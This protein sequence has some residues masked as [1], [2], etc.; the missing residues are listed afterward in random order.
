MLAIGALMSVL[1][2]AILTG[3]SSALTSSGSAPPTAGDSFEPVLGMPATNVVMIGASLSAGEDWALGSLGTVPA[4]VDGESYS[5]QTALLEHSEAPA[6]PEASGWQI[7]PLPPKPGGGTLSAGDG[8]TTPDGGVALLSNGG[9]LTRDPGGQVQLVSEP[10]PGQLGKDE[11]LPP[12]SSSI[13][14][15]AIEDGDHTGILAI[16]GGDG[17]DISTRVLHYDE[18]RWT[19]EAIEGPST[20]EPGFTPEALACAGASSTEAAAGASG[21]CWLLASYSTEASTG[22]TGRL[23]LFHRVSAKASGEEWQEQTIADERPLLGELKLK[24]GESPSVTALA[25]GAQML[26]ATTQGVWIDFQAKAG[27]G[28]SVD[29]TKLIVPSSSTTAKS[30]GTW[31]FTTD[32]SY[33]S[34][35]LCSESHWHG[36]LL[37]GQYRSFAWPGAGGSQGSRIITGLPN[38]KMLELAGES[39]SEVLGAGGQSGL[40]PGGAA[41]GEPDQGWIADGVEVPSGGLYVDGEG[42]SQVIDVTSHPAG[43]E[44]GEEAVPFRRPLYALAQAPSTTPGDPGAEAIAVGEQGEVARY[45]PGQGWRTESLYDS[46]GQAQTPTLRG[47]AWPTPGRAY[48]VGDNG[49]MWLWQA[50][51][52]LWEPDPA[53]PLNFVKHLTAIAFSAS[54]PNLGYAVGRQGALLRFGKSWEQEPLPPELEE[55]NFTSVAF[56]GSEA[57]ATYRKLEGTNEVGGLA[58]REGSE[59][60]H[61][62]PGVKALF[63]QLPSTQTVLSRVA[64]LADGGAVAAGPGLVIERDSSSGTWRFS[65]QPLPEAQNISALAAYREPGGPVRAVVSID[66]DRY[67]NPQFWDGYLE[68]ERSPF[69]VDIPPTTVAGEPS[70]FLPPDILPN[71]GYV[72]KETATG[73]SDIEHEALPMTETPDD[74]VRP[75]PVLAL[76][77]AP[78]GASG[79]AVGGQT[80]DIE[81]LGPKLGVNIG[82]I[83]HQT[84]AAMRFPAAEASSDG[85]TQAPVKTKPGKPSF[86]VGGEARCE[87]SCAQFVNEGIGPEAWLEHAL[88]SANQIAAGSPG[89]M[90]AF[91]YT[92]ASRNDVFPSVTSRYGASLPVYG[93]ESGA[94]SLGVKH[95]P[96]GAAYS[97]ESE[98]SGGPVRVIVLTFTEGSGAEGS[99]QQWLKEE[100]ENARSLRQPAIVTGRDSIGFTVP[101]GPSPPT[102]SRVATSALSSILVNGGA[103]A[104]FFDAPESDVAGT[105]SSGGKSIP[106][107]GTGTLGYVAPANETSEAD[108]LGSSGFL[109]AEVD[110]AERNPE[111][112]V[113]PLTVA[114]VPN[115]SQLALDAD[116]GVLLRRSQVA[117]FEALARRPNGGASVGNTANG[118]EW[119]G[120]DPYDPIPFNCLGAN[121][122]DAVPIDYTFTSSNPDIGAFVAHESASSNPRQVLLGSNQLPVLDEPRNSKGELNAGDHF[123][124]NANGEPINEKGQVVSHD[125]SALFCAF[126]AG[127]TIVSITT[128][129]LTYSE[130]VT[131]QAGSVE[132]PCGTV[133]LID[134]PSR[135]LPAKVDIAAPEA[136]SPPSPEATPQI[137]TL[138]PPPPPVVAPHPKPPP[139]PTS[140]PFVPLVQ[141][142]GSQVPA[143]VPPPPPLVARPI[144][145]S[146]TAQVVDEKREEESAQELANTRSSAAAYDSA[147]RSGPGPWII[148]LVV[149]AAGAGAGVR[150]GRRRDARERPAF[151]LS[152]SRQRRR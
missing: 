96:I 79:L 46:A 120:P 24:P 150:R 98:G 42:Q 102:V 122:V 26:T 64:G 71:S 6:H 104:Y 147:E 126:N 69:R 60:W 140:L 74:P 144:P 106:T 82:D 127:T 124:E 45:I 19:P 54:N 128:G 149:I 14:Y 43:D 32:E 3:R 18:G 25:K 34:G 133:P 12:Q 111:T 17:K 117:L 44:L 136:P 85:A 33:P 16:P 135:E 91:L 27:S 93:P 73:W 68:T 7:L 57:L 89:G 78:S 38:R 145:P 62:D 101:Q 130:P 2:V 50:D 115:I 65:S 59:P 4:I 75:D 63:A 29:V 56:A 99:E 9:L 66:L 94:T 83:H 146:G 35:A 76:V 58:V 97:F 84:A 138:A 8:V 103:S 129:G 49:S 110:S 112:N 55:V 37:P 67:L 114:A 81:G 11:S 121:C 123:D 137:Q 5:N 134:P 143:I 20:K 109:L 148:L 77:V 105:I 13:P 152:S 95:A 47:V 41:F 22:A 80:G 142:Q 132:Y 28:E 151:A 30:Q 48:A 15:A 125:Q 116:D 119:V 139:P 36:G 113:A 100:L 31:C 40:V 10:E 72:L 70:A 23:A 108:S 141:P 52:G 53:K 131:V 87:S 1:V 118:A 61:V 21:N 90:R 107:F 86:V 88:E 92:S 39:F 51:T